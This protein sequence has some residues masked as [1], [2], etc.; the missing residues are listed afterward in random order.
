MMR[1]LRRLRA[2]TMAPPRAD[3]NEIFWAWAGSEAATSA[4]AV[5]K[6]VIRRASDR[7][8]RNGATA[9]ARGARDDAAVG[10]ERLYVM[11]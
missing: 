3:W 8:N 6:V 7:T 9:R 2:G 11:A 1:V 4:A 5:T 10:V